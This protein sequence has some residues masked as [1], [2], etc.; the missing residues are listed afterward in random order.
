MAQKLVEVVAE[1]D[2]WLEVRW[3]RGSK[4]KGG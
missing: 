4:A 2:S 1:R 3:L